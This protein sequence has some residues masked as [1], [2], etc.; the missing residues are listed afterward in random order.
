MPCCH[1]VHLNHIFSP[2]FVRRGAEVRLLLVA[3]VAQAK[4]STSGFVCYSACAF[5]VCVS[6]RAVPSLAAAVLL[7]PSLV[8]SRAFVHCDCVSAAP[9]QVLHF[10][11]PALKLCLLMRFA[12]LIS[13]SALCLYV[14][15]SVVVFAC[16]FV[17]AWVLLARFASARGVCLFDIRCIRASRA[18]PFVVLCAYVFSASF[19]SVSSYPRWRAAH[20]RRALPLCFCPPLLRYVLRSVFVCICAFYL[21]VAVDSRFICCV[22]LSPPFLRCVCVCPPVLLCLLPSS[23]CVAC[24]VLRVSFRVS[25]FVDVFLSPLGPCFPCCASPSCVGYCRVVTDHVGFIAALAAGCGCCVFSLCVFL[26]AVQALCLSLPYFI[27]VSLVILPFSDISFC[28][29]CLCLLLC[30]AT[31]AFVVPPSVV[32]YLFLFL[33]LCFGVRSVVRPCA[34]DA[35][36][37]SFQFSLCCCFSERRRPFPFTFPAVR[38]CVLCFLLFGRWWL[39]WLPLRPMFSFCFWLASRP[40]MWCCRACRTTRCNAFPPHLS[41]CCAEDLQLVSHVLPPVAPLCVL[42]STPCLRCVL[43]VFAGACVFVVFAKRLP[44]ACQRSLLACWCYPAFVRLSG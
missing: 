4:K 17:A 22:L 43:R 11:L 9:F 23:P 19:V 33:A 39:S 10:L 40:V 13:M 8:V 26:V 24:S 41:F 7:Q 37:L 27:C 29:L 5:L 2:A 3:F 25:F 28:C 36:A 42:F 38:R 44:C 34:L 30:A 20:A 14:S 32:L 35:S 6:S 1:L 16:W 18:L 31:R 12:C 21:C 15:L